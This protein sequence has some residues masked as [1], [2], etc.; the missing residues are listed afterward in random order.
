MGGGKNRVFSMQ[1]D[2]D[3]LEGHE[4]RE[5]IRRSLSPKLP[6][7][8]YIITDS[9]GDAIGSCDDCAAYF[10]SM[11]EPAPCEKCEQVKE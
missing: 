4:E 2:P 6:K 9:E 8:R 1:D 7:G 10:E 5:Q 11:G 3:G